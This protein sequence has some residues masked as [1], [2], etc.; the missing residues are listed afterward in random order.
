MNVSGRL[1]RRATWNLQLGSLWTTSHVAQPRRDPRRE[2]GQLTG[3]GATTAGIPPDRVKPGC[4]GQRL[5][6]EIDA[7]PTGIFWG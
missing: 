6:G 5:V 7:D 1:V 4:D 3:V 2:A